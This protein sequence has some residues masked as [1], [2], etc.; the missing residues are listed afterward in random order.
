MEESI[1]HTTYFCILHTAYYVLVY[2]ILH[3]CSYCYHEVLLLQVSVKQV[4]PG[5]VTSRPTGSFSLTV[6]MI[7]V[8]SLLSPLGTTVVW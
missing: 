8:P 2:C 4:V 5:M 7:T 6:V 3:V 1:L